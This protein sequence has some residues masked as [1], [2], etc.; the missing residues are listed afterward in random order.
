MTMHHH[1]QL[2]DGSVVRF[3]GSEDSPLTAKAF[4]T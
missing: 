3:R 1:W 4:A 2:Q